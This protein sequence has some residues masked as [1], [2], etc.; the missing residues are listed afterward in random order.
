MRP[1]SQ[2]LEDVLLAV[3]L[4]PGTRS[5]KY[6]KNAGVIKVKIQTEIA[7]VPARPHTIMASFVMNALKICLSG[8]G[9]SVLPVHLTPTTIL[10]LRLAQ[11]V[12]KVWNMIGAK[13]CVRSQN[14]YYN[15]NT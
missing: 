8:T 5:T 14:D 3:L 1:M 11:S 10:A 15:Q 2:M 7:S 6:A 9:K 13:D 12:L 4:Q